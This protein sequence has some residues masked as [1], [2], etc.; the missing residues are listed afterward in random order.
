MTGM[1]FFPLIVI[2]LSVFSLAPARVWAQRLACSPCSL[3]FHEVKVGTS[4]SLSIELTNT[5][6]RSLRILSKS[7]QGPEFSFGHFGPLPMTVRPGKTVTLPVV[8]KPTAAGHVTG[9]L[10][11]VTT[12]PEKRTPLLVAGNGV[13]TS[14]TTLSV[15]PSTLNFGNVIVGQSATLPATLTASNGDV[16]VSSDQLTSSEFSITGL[17][18][19]VTIPSG[20]SVQATLQFTPNQSGTA[21]GKIGYFSGAVGSPTVEQL[22]GNGVVQGAHS[23][24][25]TWQDADSSVV[26]YNIYRGTA[27]GGPYA[28]INSALDSA[29]SYTDSNVVAG[30][31]YYYVTTALDGSGQQ[32]AYSNESKTAIPTP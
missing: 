31:T 2:A 24:D 16:T 12:A 3:H 17:N 7:K 18:L 11:L 8:F 21:S 19:P 5:G 25:L 20:Q 29:T 10:T 9:S 1:R 6:T 13:S 23:A 27:H 15:T 22:S 4:K 26:G 14:D 32:S 30:A 28:Q